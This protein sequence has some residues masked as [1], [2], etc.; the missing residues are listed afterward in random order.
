MTLTF[1]IRIAVAIDSGGEWTA[2]GWGNLKEWEPA[3]ME[4]A[5]STVGS[6]AAQ[7]WIEVELP[8]PEAASSERTRVAP[9]VRVI[10]ER[11]S[12]PG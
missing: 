1:K 4:T 5:C 12:E 7:Y 10:P 8:V 11:R 9:R 6:D 2:S 3:A